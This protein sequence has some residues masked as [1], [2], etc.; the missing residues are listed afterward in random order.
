MAKKKDIVSTIVHQQI[1]QQGKSLKTCIRT[2][3]IE[4][5]KKTKPEQTNKE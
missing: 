4:S 5:E 1:G 3:K 2:Y